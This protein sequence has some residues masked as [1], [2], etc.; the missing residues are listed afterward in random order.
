MDGVLF[1]FFGASEILETAKRIRNAEVGLLDAGE[2]FLV[3]LFLEGLGGFE[4]DVGVTIFCVEVSDNFGVFLF[5][6]P[7]VVVNA[8]IAV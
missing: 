6:K 2:H 5:A 1:A 8:A 7:G 4:N 3:E